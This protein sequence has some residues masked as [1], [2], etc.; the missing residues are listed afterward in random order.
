[1][2]NSGLAKRRLSYSGSLTTVGGLKS[3]FTLSFR[4]EAWCTGEMLLVEGHASCNRGSV[5]RVY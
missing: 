4:I 5:Y 3:C 2:W 1:M